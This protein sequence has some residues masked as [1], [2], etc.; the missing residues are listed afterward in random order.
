MSAIKFRNIWGAAGSDLDQQRGDLFRLAINL[1][2]ALGGSGKWNDAVQFAVQKFP[3]PQRSREMIP[4]KYLNQTNH[5]LGA[6]T[7]SGEI[8]IPI[9][10]AF[11]RDTAKILEEW[12]WM[13]SHPGTGGVALTSKIKSNGYFYWLIPNLDVTKVPDSIT[14]AASANT[15]VDGGAYAIEGILIKGFKPSEADMD[16][17][18]NLVFL[19]LTLQIDRYYP[20]KTSDLRIIT[21][22]QGG[23]TNG[24]TDSAFNPAAG[25]VTSAFG[26]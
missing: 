4:I 19:N 11:N 8:E 9:R 20:I 16:S 6:D 15:M 2:A 14:E 25:V 1:P 7:A 26:L 23:S 17:S 3:F 24:G 22:G 12:H 5:Q 10:Y 21:S 18:S 13:H